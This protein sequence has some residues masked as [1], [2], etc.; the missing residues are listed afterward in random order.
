MSDLENANSVFDISVKLCAAIEK[1]KCLYDRN[2][3]RK[4]STPECEK[5]WQVVAKECNQ[6]VDYCRNRWKNLLRA[7]YQ[8]I[9]RRGN[10][11]YLHDY[12]SYLLEDENKAKSKR[13]PEATLNDETNSTITHD[14]IV[15]VDDDEAEESDSNTNS[16]DESNEKIDGNKSQGG[17]GGFIIDEIGEEA[18]E[19]ENRERRLSYKRSCKRGLDPEL[20]GD[21]GD[22]DSQEPG[23]KRSR[24]VLKEGGKRSEHND[25]ELLSN[26]KVVVRM[27]KIKINKPFNDNKSAEELEEMRSKMIK[28]TMNSTERFSM[29]TKTSTPKAV[30]MVDSSTSTAVATRCMG[31][32]YENSIDFMDYDEIFMQSIKQRLQEMNARQK[33]NFKAKIYKSLLEVFDDTADFPGSNEVLKLPHKKPQVINTTTG[34]LRLMRE[35]VSLVQAAKSTPEIVNAKEK[36]KT[37]T[38]MAP[39]PAAQTVPAPIASKTPIKLPMP[40]NTDNSSKAQISPLS[41]SPTLDDDDFQFSLDNIDDD[42]DLDLPRTW[43]E[44]KAKPSEPAKTAASVTPTVEENVM[45]LPRRILQ[46]VVRVSGSSGSTIVARDGD[47]KR[48][49]RIY[50]KTMNPNNNTTSSTIANKNTNMGTFYVTPA[51]GPGETGSAQNTNKNQSN[52]SNI[53][54]RSFNTNNINNNITPVTTSNSDATT[55]ANS[56]NQSTAT[57][58]GNQTAFKNVHP[59]N[60]ILSS[61][62]GLFK[63]VPSPKPLTN[64]INQ[65]PANVQTTSNFPTSTVT[66]VTAMSKNPM[67]PP[68]SAN[69]AA[70]RQIVRSHINAPQIMQRRYSICGPLPAEKTQPT[71]T[72]MT[73]SPITSKG[74]NALNNRPQTQSSNSSSVSQIQISQPISL[75]TAAAKTSNTQTLPTRSVSDY[76]TPVADIK[77]SFKEPAANKP[78]TPAAST[79]EIPIL[80]TAGTVGVDVLDPLF[81]KQSHIKSE[82]SDD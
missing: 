46:K 12:M 31:T 45:G 11:Y 27:D 75:N 77:I 44:I 6:T 79:E 35:L 82:P 61:T 52:M 47:R 62:T 21:L 70:K 63:T 3:V 48:I 55:S 72:T 69:L 37:I 18:G 60:R 74:L 8:G 15:N 81:V 22:E 51:K 5:A 49:Y 66:K 30:K 1:H 13:Q 2:S 73:G 41:L 34:E 17:G 57:N 80:E 38:A 42:D 32:Q 71:P 59:A 19:G 56:S 65:K 20:L 53:T 9:N 64:P 16:A 28:D 43:E 23:S 78:K 29:E 7:F 26:K 54:V 76:S 33:M 4:N 10:P 25:L 68:T 58:S 67:L 14:D 24:K 50:P 39:A 36:V 40:N